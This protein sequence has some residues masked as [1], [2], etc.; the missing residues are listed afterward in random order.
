MLCL[1]CV[2]AAND[3]HFVL[4]QFKI[5]N[6][7]TGKEWWVPAS[8]IDGNTCKWYAGP[9]AAQKTVTVYVKD[10]AGNTANGTLEVN[11]A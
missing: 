2:K 6:L 10:A 5:K 7:K 8:D 4:C 11:V 9:E 1:A 3:I